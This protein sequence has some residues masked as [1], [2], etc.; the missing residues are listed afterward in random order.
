MFLFFELAT[1]HDITD[2]MEKSFFVTYTKM[3]E[4]DSII[5]YG[6]GMS[7]PLLYAKIEF[8]NTEAWKN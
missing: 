4:I 2:C 8:D 6:I 3:L 5:V 7:Q 1:R